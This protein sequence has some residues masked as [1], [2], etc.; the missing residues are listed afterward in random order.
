MLGLKTLLPFAFL[1]LLPH[2]EVFTLWVIQETTILAICVIQTPTHKWLAVCPY[3]V[4][5][6]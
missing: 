3:F 1:P 6:V 5:I 4:P 2:F